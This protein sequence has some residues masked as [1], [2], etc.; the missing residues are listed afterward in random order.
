MG[1]KKIIT[2]N[3]L[4]GWAQVIHESAE[5]WR[6]KHQDDLDAMTTED[7]KGL[8]FEQIEGAMSYLSFRG[9]KSKFSREDVVKALQGALYI[10]SVRQPE[11]TPTRSVICGPCSLG[12]HADAVNKVCPDTRCTCYCRTTKIEE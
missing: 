4:D 7:L 10:Q 6:K 3:S 5:I 1:T 12:Q 2:A 9:Y 8:A 11:P